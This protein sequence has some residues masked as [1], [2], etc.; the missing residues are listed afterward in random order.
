MSNRILKILGGVVLLVLLAS[1]AVLA[2]RGWGGVDGVEDLPVFKV[3]RGDLVRR[4][5]AEG[6]LVAA[7]A[8]PLGPVMW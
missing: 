5:R 3:S 4:I 6:N 1:V 8:T 7:K 2:L